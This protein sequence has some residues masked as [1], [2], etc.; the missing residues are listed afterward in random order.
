VGGVLEELLPDKEI[1]DGTSRDIAL[2]A[3]QK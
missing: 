3:V 1:I 2:Y